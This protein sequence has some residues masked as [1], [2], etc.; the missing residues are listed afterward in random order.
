M[1]L[2]SIFL[3]KQTFITILHLKTHISLTH[4]F[5]LVFPQSPLY[6]VEINP[7]FSEQYVNVVKLHLCRESPLYCIPSLSANCHLL[8][9]ESVFAACLVSSCVH[10]EAG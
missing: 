3:N 2:M 10:E 5:W 4:Q 8:G 7:Q 9:S 6:L 1:F